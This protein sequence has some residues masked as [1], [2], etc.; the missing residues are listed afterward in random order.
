MYELKENVLEK[1]SDELKEPSRFRVMLVNDDYTTMDF[2][3]MVLMLVFHKSLGE[4]QQLMLTVHRAGKAVCGVYTFEIAETKVAQVE[5][6]AE[7]HKF[8]LRCTMEEE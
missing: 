3:V 5:A 1:V 6:I 2:V 8:P 4:A 7:Q